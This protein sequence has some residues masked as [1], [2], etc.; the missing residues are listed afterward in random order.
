M[1]ALGVFVLVILL[2]YWVG[3]TLGFRRGVDA[4]HSV[5]RG[6]VPTMD[7]RVGALPAPPLPLTPPP[8]MG[9]GRTVPNRTGV[10]PPPAPGTNGHTAGGAKVNTGGVGGNVGGN[11]GVNAAGGNSG[12]SGGGGIRIVAVARDLR[13]VGLNYYVANAYSEADAIQFVGYLWQEGVEAEAIKLHNRELFLV[14]AMPGFKREELGSPAWTKLGRELDQ[15]VRQFNAERRR[16]VIRAP[17][18]ADKYDGKPAEKVLTR[19]NQP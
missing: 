12:G 4:D 7:G 5:G 19:E 10:T 3:D 6:N 2:A 17:L 8:G 9:G 13:V 16:Q 15:L 11:I 14:V 1:L 18:Y